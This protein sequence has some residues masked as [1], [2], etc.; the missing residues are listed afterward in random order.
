M[1]TPAQL[2]TVPSD[3][4]ARQEAPEMALI[5]FQPVVDTIEK[6]TTSRLPQYPK[7]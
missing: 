7:E 6:I 4:A 1:I 5:A 3:S 2:G